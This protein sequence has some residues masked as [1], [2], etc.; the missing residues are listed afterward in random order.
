MNA[1]GAPR[2]PDL[3]GGEGGEQDPEEMSEARDSIVDLPSII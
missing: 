2:T 1:I 3:R